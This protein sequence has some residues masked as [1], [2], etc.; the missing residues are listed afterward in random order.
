MAE[1]RLD[2]IRTHTHT[3]TNTHTHLL[4]YRHKLRKQRKQL[5][6]YPVSQSEIALSIR[7]L[8]SQYTVLQRKLKC[9]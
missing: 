4:V 2:A 8:V 9:P 7:P 5:A 6:T 3:H 1:I